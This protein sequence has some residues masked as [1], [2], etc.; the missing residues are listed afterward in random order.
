MILVAEEL[1][2]QENDSGLFIK[3]NGHITAAV[4]TDLREL[5][6]GRLTKAPVPPLLAVDLSSCEYMDS[7]FMGLLVGFHKRYKVLT[8]RALTILRPSPEC[9]KLLTGLGILKLMLLV[10]GGEPASPDVWTSLRPQRAPSTEIL[11]HAHQNLSELSPEN[12]KKFSVLQGVL[13]RELE[14]KDPS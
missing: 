9:I 1:Y 5:I 2:Y 6:L 12:E 8:G 7:T 13:Q 3:A 10:T 14:K 11:L 4:S